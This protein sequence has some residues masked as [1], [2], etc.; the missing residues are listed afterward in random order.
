MGDYL[1]SF[2]TETTSI[3]LVGGGKNIEIP[4]TKRP[5]R[6]KVRYTEIQFFSLDANTWTLSA[7]VPNQGEFFAFLTLDKSS[8]PD[9]E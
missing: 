2:K 4:C 1:A 9:D 6:K 3:L 7:V 5:G 8:A